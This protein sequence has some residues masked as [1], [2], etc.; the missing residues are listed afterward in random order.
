MPVP[1]L[2]TERL[3]MQGHR[4]DDYDETAAMWADP[5][6]TLHIGGR[7]STPEESWYRLLRNVGHWEVMGFGYWVIRERATARFVGEVGFADLRRALEPALGNA[8][9]MGW[10]LAPW[11]HG[12][13]FATEAVRA[14]LAW[15]DRTWGPRRTVCLID[16]GNVA[17][18]RVAEK[19]GFR[20]LVKTTYH[21]TPTVLFERL[22]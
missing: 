1:T 9:E 21:G 11:A 19:V 16:P 12:K 20:E 17:S 3:I 7:P 8:P 18:R 13:G 10:V 5:V 6:V 14:G 22:P 4:V 2:E 15:G